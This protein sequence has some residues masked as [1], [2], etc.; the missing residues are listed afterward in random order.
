MP[1]DVIELALSADCKMHLS[2]YHAQ[3]NFSELEAKRKII[4]VHFSLRQP[5]Q[6]AV[7]DSLSLMHLGSISTCC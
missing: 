2:F 5:F 1:I 3:L 7:N 4:A 6:E